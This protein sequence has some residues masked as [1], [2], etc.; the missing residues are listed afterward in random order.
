MTNKTKE[1]IKHDYQHLIDQIIF[2]Y[3]KGW[4]Y[5]EETR[6]KV[7]NNI[8]NFVGKKNDINKQKLIKDINNA[9]IFQTY[10]KEFDEIAKI[11]KKLR[12]D[13]NNES[14]F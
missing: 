13:S 14:H 4:G 2:M 3:D 7:F 11:L 12:K 8:I 5:S 1:Q 6:N 9:L 10:K